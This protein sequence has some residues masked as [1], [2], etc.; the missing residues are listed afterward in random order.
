MSGPSAVAG[1]RIYRSPYPDPVIPAVDLASFTLRGA[2]RWPERAALVDGATGAT[3]RYGQ[4]LAGVSRARQ[5]LVDLGVLPGAPVVLSAANQPAWVVAFYA[6]LSA[7]ATVVPLNPALT[8]AELRPMLALARPDFV[9]ADPAG[10]P[11][12]AEA[13]GMGSPAALVALCD[14]VP[15]VPG[16]PAAADASVP[17]PGPRPPGP[18]RPAVLAFSSGTTGRAKAVQLSQANL[19]ATLVQHEP[20]YHVGA[21]DVLLAPM[22][23]FH[24]Y[25]LSI[26]LGYALRH[27]AT[28]V[29][30]PRF[31]LET[32]C[33]LAGQH[34][35]TWLHLVPPMVL[36]LTRRGTRDGLGSVRHAVCGAA[37]LDASLAEEAGALLGCAVGQGYGMTEA[38]P[39]VTWVP[40]DGSVPCPQGSVGVLVP[41]TEARLVDPST[42]QDAGDTGELW[43]RGPQVMAGYLGDPAATAQVLTDD[44]WLRTG[45]VLRVDG[46]G[47]W[48][49]VDRIKELIKF[50]GWQVAP[51]ELEA[52]LLEHPAVVDAAVAGVADAEAGEVPVA[53]VVTRRPTGP[54]DLL[55]WVAGRVAPHKKVRRVHFVDRLPRSPSGKLLRRT[56]VEPSRPP[57]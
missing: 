44:G 48:W 45:D 30:M 50:K 57:G 22:P 5:L 27:G 2:A 8:A 26:V 35:A 47:V 15:D 40:D 28:V 6:A 29:T 41:G 32:Y 25:G 39:G 42:G 51:A 19:V 55:A 38:S 9:I 16:A 46:T 52:V 53:W 49:V 56:L 33:R 21:G 20:V 54:E 12:L 37:P 34:G 43:I 18:P 10:R 3:W 4:L 24:I 17:G 14:L 13:V 7:G 1:P 23:L 31:D 11:S 36:G